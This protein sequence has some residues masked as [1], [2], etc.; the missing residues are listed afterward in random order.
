MTIDDVKKSIADF[1][2]GQT[3]LSQEEALR[4]FLEKEEVPLY[5]KMDKRLILSLRKKERPNAPEQLENRLSELIDRE[6]AKERPMSSSRKKR[7]LFWGSSI[8]A[9][10]VVALGLG[11]FMDSLGPKAPAQPQVPQEA[12]CQILQSALVEVSTELNS[13][14][15]EVEKSQKEIRKVN[16]D[17]QKE[18][19]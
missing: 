6:A 11:Y 14:I 7:F 19:K 13:G 4:N 9:M 18:I 12:V 1:Y 2:E 5:L 16:K 8:A 15:E 3:T 17:V 10:L